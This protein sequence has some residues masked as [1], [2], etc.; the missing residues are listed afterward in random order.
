MPRKFARKRAH[1][2]HMLRNLITSVVLYERVTTTQAKAKE[3]KSMIDSLIVAGKKNDLATRRRLNAFF[4]DQNATKKILEDLVPRYESRNSGF[5]RLFH[6]TPR[7]GD[8]APQAII[9][10]IPG[11]KPKAKVETTIE[12]KSDKNTKDIKE[13]KTVKDKENDKKDVKT[14]DTNKTKKTKENSTSKSSK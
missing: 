12:K 5:T 2:N 8:S 13:T 3:A 7:L 9:E 1:R 14:K 10:L 11:E 6:L 4:F